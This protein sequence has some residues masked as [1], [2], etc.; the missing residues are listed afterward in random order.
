MGQPTPGRKCILCCCVD[1]RENLALLQHQVNPYEPYGPRRPGVLIH[2]TEDGGLSQTLDLTKDVDKNTTIVL[3]CHRDCAAIGG[4]LDTYG[5]P[6]KKLSS[7]QLTW[8]RTHGDLLEYV[9]SSTKG[10]NLDRRQIITIL[11]KASAIQS[12]NNIFEYINRTKM[13]AEPGF[14]ATYSV[15]PSRPVPKD[16]PPTSIGLMV[17]DPAQMTFVSSYN[18]GTNDG[19]RMADL[20]DESFVPVSD[21]RIA[22]RID[23]KAVVKNL[24]AEELSGTTSKLIARHNPALDG[25]DVHPQNH[26]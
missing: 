22:D 23:I 20:F 16:L 15:S 2:N 19:C 1:P 25:P 4:F 8:W 14:Y 3:Q 24:I 26:R 6:H 18:A 21:L 12:I 10:L 9:V 7:S 17:F 11:T 13:D 5:V